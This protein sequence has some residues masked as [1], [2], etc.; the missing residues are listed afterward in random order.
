M[1][2]LKPNQFLLDDH[3]IT[4]HPILFS[5]EMVKANKEDRKTNTRRTKGLVSYSEKH[6]PM[7]FFRDEFRED[8]WEFFA[9]TLKDGKQTETPN[10]KS[11]YGKPGDLLYVR[12]NW[13][14]IEAR[15][16]FQAD[17]AEDELK[18]EYSLDKIRWKP[19]IHL[20][21]SGSRIWAMV[22]DIRVERVKD[23]SEEDAKAEGVK[24]NIIYDES[25]PQDKSH[26]IS[27]FK[28]YLTDY[29]GAFGNIAGDREEEHDAAK[30]S[31]Q[32]LWVSINGQSSWDA[33]PW[34]WVIKYRILSKTGRPSMDMIEQAYSEIVNKKSEILNTPTP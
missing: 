32:S 12:E 3:L 14:R 7:E 27:F 16:Y 18:E 1:S 33:N 26:S 5:T 25:Y 20:P 23:I 30:S 24:E 8:E 11:P 9:L 22:E 31:F 34:V 6:N 21:K 19:S 15:I 4:E 10:I 28:S 29:W 17:E 13:S 2:K